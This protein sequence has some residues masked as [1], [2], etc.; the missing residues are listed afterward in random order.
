[1]VGIRTAEPSDRLDFGRAVTPWQWLVKHREALWIGVILLVAGLMHGINMFGLPYFENDEGVYMSQAWSVL[2]QGQLAPYTYWYDHAPFGWIQIAGW[3]AITG[4][5]ASFGFSV[6]SGRILMLLF[7]LGSTFMLYKIARRVSG[8]AFVGGFAALAFATSAWGIYYHRRVLLDNVTTFWMLASI[9]LLLAPRLSLRRVWLSAV[10]LAF[11]ILS[12]ELT[13]FLAPAVAYLVLY[14]SHRGQ[15]GF[16]VATWCAILLSVVSLYVLMAILKGEL[17]PPGTLWFENSHP[18]T[19]LLGGLE[20]QGSRSR[21]GGIMNMK[22]G[23]WVAMSGWSLSDPFL[24]IGGLA[25]SVVSILRL[26]WNRLVG[27]MGLLTLS[28]FAFLARGGEVL[29]FYL[30]PLLPL[31]ALNIGL[32]VGFL[33]GV[34]KR[35]AGLTFPHIGKFNFRIEVLASSALTIAAVPLVVAG[36]HTKQLSFASDPAQLWTS[37]Q[38]RAQIL[39]LQWVR[40][41][42]SENKCVITDNYL[43]VDLAAGLD[44]GPKY[45]CVH[46]YRK[47]DA[48]PAISG[49]VFHNRWQTADYIIATPPLVEDASHTWEHMTIVEAAVKN[50]VLI[51]HFD[52]G[53]WPVNIL[54]VNNGTNV[55]ATTRIAPV[56][57][58]ARHRT[59]RPSPGT[60]KT[61]ASQAASAAVTFGFGPSVPQPLTLAKEQLALIDGSAE[62]PG[63][64]GVTPRNAGPAARARVTTAQQ[65]KK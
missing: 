41:N 47:V 58:V 42:I 28:L 32:T 16:A 26:R 59:T 54:R 12:K 65:V 60:V 19:S 53:G 2:S 15:R 13:V 29:T 48:D 4:G 1:V 27:I 31:F 10:A 3:N 6:Y 36:Y 52:T 33:I 14:R 57:T 9:L 22:S 63:R 7:Q 43:W 38:S 49:P 61:V 17:F 40:A 51:K 23:F 39:A 5:I 46:W 25:G 21:D 44:N 34:V 24:L 35:V 56:V 20:Y 18:H 8:S 45:T 30:I 64:F 62:S 11:S 50:S 37:S 55:T